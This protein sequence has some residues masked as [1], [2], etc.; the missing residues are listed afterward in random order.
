M[1]Y[2]VFRTTPGPICEGGTP[3]DTEEV[4]CRRARLALE[5]QGFGDETYVREYPGGRLVA[6]FVRDLYSIDPVAEPP[7]WA[8]RPLRWQSLV[9][10]DGT[11]SC[12][13]GEAE[14]LGL[15]D[16]LQASKGWAEGLVLHG[17]LGPFRNREEALCATLERGDHA[18]VPHVHPSQVDWS[19]F[20]RAIA[21]AA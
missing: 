9:V 8:K 17:L 18:L 10:S 3:P 15:L 20:E 13:L 11:T 19:G 1:E 2:R 14:A 16:V 6:A 12:T 5:F 4:A 21:R 7:S